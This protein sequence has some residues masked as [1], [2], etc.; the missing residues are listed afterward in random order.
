MSR[1]TLKMRDALAELNAKVDNMSLDVK[2]AQGTA[3]MQSKMYD[4][5]AALFVRIACIN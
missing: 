1:T 3:K 5:Q 4:N 2:D